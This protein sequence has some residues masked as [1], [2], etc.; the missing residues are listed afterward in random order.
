MRVILGI[1]CY[2]SKIHFRLAKTL[3]L[4]QTSY[5]TEFV[6]GCG[7]KNPF[8]VQYISIFSSD[9]DVN[10]QHY[11]LMF[12]A[13]YTFKADWL[14]IMGS[15]QWATRQNEFSHVVEMLAVGDK[16]KAA[17]IGAPVP[18]SAGGGGYNIQVVKDEPFGHGIPPNKVFDVDRIGSGFAAYSCNWFRARWPE[19]TPEEPWFQSFPKWKDTKTRVDRYGLDYYICDKVREKGGLIL[20]DSRVAISHERTFDCSDTFGE[21]IYNKFGERQLTND[22]QGAFQPPEYRNQQTQESEKEKTK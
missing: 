14:I 10:K 8:H 19:C 7:H 9:V 21:Y 18:L 5:L 11:Q 4:F 13:M 1:P 22:Y 15:D 3:E 2:Q 17:I 16:H 6:E 20:C 12:D